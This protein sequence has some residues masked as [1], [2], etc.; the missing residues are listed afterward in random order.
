[1]SHE[2]KLLSVEVESQ[3][4]PVAASTAQVGDLSTPVCRP[5]DFRFDVSI[6]TGM[7]RPG[8]IIQ[9]WL[10]VYKHLAYAY[11]GAYSTYWVTFIIP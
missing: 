8:L 2:F 9:C 1:M 5:V 11:A 10:Q 3:V 7:L 4:R 6:E